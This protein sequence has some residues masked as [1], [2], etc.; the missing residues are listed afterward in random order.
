M[1]WGAHTR[2]NTQ[3]SKRKS[4]EEIDRMDELFAK[5]EAGEGEDLFAEEGEEVAQEAGQQAS[6]AAEQVD[7]KQQAADEKQ[8]TPAT[9]K[10]K[11]QRTRPRWGRGL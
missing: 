10:T 1:R 8:Q 4:D 3:K 11:N 7:E 2:K 9:K 6:E 5:V